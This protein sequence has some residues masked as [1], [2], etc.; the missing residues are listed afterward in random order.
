MRKP[1]INPRGPISRKASGN[2]V[3]LTLNEKEQEAVNALLAKGFYG[4]T[5]A[6]AVRRILDKAL[7]EMADKGMETPL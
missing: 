1:P 7:L 2:I 3:Y 6:E 5:P 4:S